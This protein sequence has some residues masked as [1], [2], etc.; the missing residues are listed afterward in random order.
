MGVIL[1]IVLSVAASCP[2]V[3]ANGD[4]ALA[5]LIDDGAR[6]SATFRR[7]VTAIDRTNG[8]VYVEQGKCGHGVRACLTLSVKVAGPHRILRILVDLR[9]DL[10]E[11]LGALGHELQHALELLGDAR[12]TSNEAA[13]LFYL[14]A[15]P[16]SNDR[17][18]TQAAIAAGFQVEREA[19]ASTA[20]RVQP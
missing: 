3:R 5:A 20:R 16:T 15:A 6:V 8:L 1:T 19:H 4:P 18:E 17:F 10:F 14:A 2:H 13:Y 11:L 9:R 12:V 7:L